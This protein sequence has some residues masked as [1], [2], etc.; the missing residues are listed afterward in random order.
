MRHVTINKRLAIQP[1]IVS[2]NL[3]CAVQLSVD[4]AAHLIA[5][6]EISHRARHD[7][8]SV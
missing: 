1:G 5:S 6:R 8:T 2:L 4:I 7:G 3:T